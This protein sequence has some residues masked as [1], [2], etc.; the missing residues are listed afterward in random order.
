MRNRTN[1]LAKH[2]NEVEAER[3][4]KMPIEQNC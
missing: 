3:S 2:E 1:F 4:E